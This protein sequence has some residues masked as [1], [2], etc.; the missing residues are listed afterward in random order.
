MLN[1]QL[2]DLQNNCTIKRLLDKK[3]A[4]ACPLLAF[5]LLVPTARL[6]LAQLSP[7][8]PQDS[9]STNFT[10]SAKDQY[11]NLF[12]SFCSTRIALKQEGNRRENQGLIQPYFGIWLACPPA[13]AGAGADGV[14]AAGEVPVDA[15]GGFAGACVAGTDASGAGAAGAVGRFSI[16]PPLT[17]PCL[18]PIK[19]SA[20]VAPKKIAAARAVD[21]DKK[22]EEP[23]APKR[24]PDAPEPNAAPM[25]APLPCCSSTRPIIARA[26]N[27]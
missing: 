26:D 1:D 10:T 9:V 12:W 22:L 27:T 25:S 18:F 8:P 20:R 24:L 5:F 3:P 19:A 4:R 6:E 15:A 23:L 13:P 7:L 17:G 21:L 2:S 16:T 14:G 11:C